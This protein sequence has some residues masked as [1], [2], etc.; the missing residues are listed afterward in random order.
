MDLNIPRGFD[1]VLDETPD[2][3]FGEIRIEGGVTVA[4]GTTPITLIANKII[5]RDGDGAG[6]NPG[7]SLNV[8][9]F[10]DQPTKCYLG[11]GTANAWGCL[12]A[13]TDTD[14]LERVQTNVWHRCDGRG[15]VGRDVHFRLTGAR[16]SIDP[17]AVSNSVI[18]GDKVIGAAEGG[19]ISMYGR[20]SNDTSPGA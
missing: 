10:N 5:V 16:T 12:T 18:V 9:K 8:C 14:L 15:P 17:Y 19:R 13:S 20:P 4:D 6:G 3:T 1:F 2:I 7:G 11:G